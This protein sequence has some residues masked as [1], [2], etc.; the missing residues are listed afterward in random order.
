MADSTTRK[1]RA[2]QRRLD[3]L[4]ACNRRARR[5]AARVLAWL[6]A[7]VSTAAKFEGYDAEGLAIYSNVVL[8]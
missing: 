6:D 8:G 2:W 5:N 3:R 1:P 7:H 4:N